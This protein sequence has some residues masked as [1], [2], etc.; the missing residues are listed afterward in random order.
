MTCSDEHVFSSLLSLVCWAVDRRCGLSGALVA[1]SGVFLALW[2]LAV[3]L[4]VVPGVAAMGNIAVVDSDVV[5]ECGGSGCG[6][7]GW[8]V[9]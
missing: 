7:R 9:W 8:G 3:A 2:V 4:V 5:A 6:T 1:V